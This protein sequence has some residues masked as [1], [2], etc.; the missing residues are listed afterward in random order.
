[1]PLTNHVAVIALPSPE[2]EARFRVQWMAKVGTPFETSSSVSFEEFRDLVD[3]MCG[4]TPFF[5]SERGD[6]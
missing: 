5:V 3:E 1:M 4:I 6:R 2:A